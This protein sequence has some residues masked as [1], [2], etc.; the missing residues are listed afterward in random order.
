MVYPDTIRKHCSI[1]LLNGDTKYLSDGALVK[2]IRPEYW[3]SHANDFVGAD[4][5]HLVYTQFGMGFVEKDCLIRGPA[6]V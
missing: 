6:W 4:G 2:F 1:K 3:P 5:F